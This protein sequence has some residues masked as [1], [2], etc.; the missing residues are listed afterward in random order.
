MDVPLSRTARR[1]F[2]RCPGDQI[3]PKPVAIENAIL[4]NGILNTKN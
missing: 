1:A 4:M 2:P 3:G